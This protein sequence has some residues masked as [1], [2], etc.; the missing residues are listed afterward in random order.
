MHCAAWYVAYTGTQAVA[1]IG[2]R[3]FFYEIVIRSRVEVF[4]RVG[5]VLANGVVCGR[6]PSAGMVP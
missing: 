6:D 2:R 5:F 4:Q 1:E 3:K